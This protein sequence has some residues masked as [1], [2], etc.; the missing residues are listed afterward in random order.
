[1][2]KNLSYLAGRKGVNKTLFEELGIAAVETGAPAKEKMEELR[3]EFLVGKANVYGTATF[4]DFLK[5]E[6]QGKKVYV[7]NGS[8]CLCAGT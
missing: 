6:N 5:P 1:M 4:Y 7:C 2:S 8:A 3:K